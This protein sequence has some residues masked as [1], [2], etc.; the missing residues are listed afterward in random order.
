MRR[1]VLCGLLVA[2]TPG[3]AASAQALSADDVAVV[4]HQRQPFRAV[5]DYR[6]VAGGPVDRVTVRAAARDLPILASP[7][8][9]Y[10]GAV[11]VVLILVDTSK[12]RRAGTLQQNA[13]DIGRMM[14]AAK[15][16][17]RVGLAV[18]DTTLRVLAPLGSPPAAVAAA[19]QSMTI[20]GLT[21]E[22]FR[23]TLTAVQMVTR[24]PA[25]RRALYILSDGGAEDTAYTLTDAVQAAAKANVAIFGLGFAEKVALSVHL[26]TLRRLGEGT[27][28]A[29]LEGDASQAL[30]DA[31]VRAP[32]KAIDGG[33]RVD[34][35]LRPAASLF[36]PTAL[37][38][39]VSLAAGGGAA[40]VEAPATVPRRPPTA[41]E[42]AGVVVVAGA[43]GVAG[44]TTWRRRRRAADVTPPEPLAYLEFLD[45]GGSVV[46][47]T[48]SQLTIG[49]SE[50]N[51]GLQLANDTVS[52]HHAT[53][54]RRRDGVFEIR[55]ILSTNGVKVNDRRVTQ[56][57]LVDGDVIAVG[58][59]R[60]R[61]RPAAGRVEA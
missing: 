54:V 41:F 45:G 20:E 27:K 4:A 21:T 36:R 59:V 57:P 7:A 60:F 31:F 17:H 24:V 39:R 3:F 12:S 37:A 5:V 56:A 6:L 14:E 15:P 10:D 52:A 33:G 46:P 51:N 1:E 16:H 48:G 28:G 34:V 35:D 29:Y 9:P 25:T 42:V 32:F 47:I 13:R 44:V 40:S 55:E 11:T 38:L 58:E 26:Q 23:H 18:L 53:I 22:L 30:P 43:V 49:R 19:A 50:D 2:V 61:F 8:Y